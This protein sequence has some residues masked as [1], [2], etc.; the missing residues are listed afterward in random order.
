[1]VLNDVLMIAGASAGTAASIQWWIGRGIHRRATA[2]LRKRH[3]LAQQ[4]AAELLG[5]CRQQIA[6]LKSELAASAEK[7][8]QVR[9]AALKVLANRST[10]E[11]DESPGRRGWQDTGGFAATQQHEDLFPRHGFARTTVMEDIHPAHGRGFAETT[12]EEL[13]RM[14]LGRP[15]PMPAR[16]RGFAWEG[17]IV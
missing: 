10:Q 6:R 8:K 9:E 2:A 7:T 15:A 4:E 3:A 5:H 11:A 17:V 16:R 12:V 1:M 14:A 13:P